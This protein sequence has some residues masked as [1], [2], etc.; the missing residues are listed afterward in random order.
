MLGGE[1]LAVEVRDGLRRWRCVAL[2]RN[3]AEGERVDG[4]DD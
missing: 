3:E 2:Y 1:S 4:F